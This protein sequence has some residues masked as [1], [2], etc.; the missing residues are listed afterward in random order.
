MKK[1]LFS[2]MAML[3]LSI[4]GIAQTTYTK[5]TSTSGLEVGANYLIVAHHDDAGILA[6]GYQK[7][8]NRHAVV[9][10]ENGESITVTPGTDPSSETDVFQ[11]TLGGSANAWTLF[12]EVKGG[13]LYAASNSSNNLKTQ[14]TLDANGQ[15]SI[16]FNGDGTAEVVAQGENGRNNMRFNPNTANNAPLFS[17]YAETS[18][19]DTR[20]SLYKAGG[21]V[22]PD[23]EPSNYPTNFTATVN[24]LSITLTWT[25]A[26]GAQLPDK[27]LVIA[28]TS[29][30][31]VPVDGT[32]VANSDMVTNVNYGVETVTFSGLVGGATYK[33]AIFPYTN[34]GSNID[35]L[36]S[37]NFPIAE[38]TTENVN[39]LIFED[40]DEDLG[41]F[42]TFDAY[43][44]QSWHQATHQGI[45]FAN[46]NGY[47][48]NAANVNE[49]WLIAQ[50][51]TILD[52]VFTEIF[53]EFRTAMKFDGDPI[54]VMV[55]GDY[56]GQSDPSDF[57]WSNITDAFEYSTGNYEWV[58][59]G[60]VNII[61][62]VG[63]FANSGNNWYV[64][65]VYNSSNEAAASW[66][67]DYVKISCNFTTS[68]NENDAQTVNLYPNPAS[69]Q[70]S[71][72]LDEAAEV[73]IFDMTGRKVSTMN[74]IAGEAQLNVS[75][76]VN[77]VY[78]VN[79]RFA[80]GSTAVS[81]FVKF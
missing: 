40:F 32:P 30:I 54:R 17:C 49:D 16:T 66:E 27:Y 19:I 31:T 48:N 59:S 72:V 39:Y 76:L 65:F 7:S 24:E 9:V 68:V 26:T 25:D 62:V 58:E 2:L 74:V 77:G 34:S 50:V 28:T 67:I 15:W 57:T 78:F 71:F 38:A 81:K 61:N 45:T 69:E 35:Y 5:V 4:S 70:I 8:N 52:V 42:T 55:S 14:T 13:Y 21:G 22:Q 3:L 29:G 12:D 63:D 73:S 41:V 44:D 18:N 20:V 36:T 33:F 53:L 11:F 60:K 80:N 43:G 56:D 37:G 64:A 75:E 23:P 1:V 46:M 10:S 51:P 6:M 47:A 79:F